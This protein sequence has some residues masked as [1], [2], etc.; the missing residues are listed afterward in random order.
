MPFRNLFSLRMLPL[1]TVGV[2]AIGLAA[3]SGGALSG[4]PLV[5]FVI[6]AALTALGLFDL[7]QREHSV[8]RNYPITAHLRFILEEVRPE[9]RQYF[10]EDDNSG[11]PFSR[12]KRSIVYQRA[13]R[14]LDKRPFGTQLDVYSEGFEWMNQSLAPRA[15][16]GH[17]FRTRI[18]GPACARPY[19]ASIFNIS[20]MSFGALS[21]NA[22][23]ALN[24]GAKRGAFAHNTGEGGFSPYHRANGGDIIWE[25]GSGYFGCRTQDGRFDPNQFAAIAT[26]DQIRMI[27][28]KLSQGAKPGHGGLLPGAKV[29]AE[30]AAIRGVEAGRDCVSPAAHAAFSTPVELL[31]FIDRLRTLSGGKPV[32][33]KLCIGQPHEFFAICKAMVATGL[34]P[35]FITI[36]GKEGGTGS[37][38][39]EFMD[40]IGMPMRDAIALAHHTLIGVDLRRHIRLAASGKITTAFDIA[41]ACAL[42]ADWCYSARGFMFALGCIQSLKCHTDRCPTGV[43]TQDPARARAL[44]PEL[45]AE[46]VFNYH[47]STLAALAELVAAAGV[48]HPLE[49]RAND[50]RVRLSEKRISSFADLYPEPATGAFLNGV[51]PENYARDW[52]EAQAESFRPASP[53]LQDRRPSTPQGE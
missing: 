24:A 11:Y 51:V 35:D 44:V 2:S 6:L 13:K 14:N 29:S 41:R 15:V 33:V 36:D 47:Q 20:A 43:A 7:L 42:G 38:P 3:F 50:F 32:G 28:I 18:G 22:I 8:L 27:E 53:C 30:I 5:A 25:I 34:L 4:G 46:R 39:L 19:D 10:V 45:K 48:S 21:A 1:L 16:N 40:H 9:I 37:A 23:L 26:L 52:L 49:L 31:G 17:D 12:N